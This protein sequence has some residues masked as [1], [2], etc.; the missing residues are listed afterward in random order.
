MSTGTQIVNDAA[1]ACG[2][3]GQGENLSADDSA[4][5]LRRLNRLMDYWSNLRGMVYEIVTDS[6]PA[7]IGTQQYSST[8]LAT[9]GRPVEVTFMYARLN[10]IDYKIDLVSSD[11]WARIPY[12]TVQSVPRVCW[13]DTSF[14][15]D[16]FNLFPVPDNVYTIFVGAQKALPNTIGMATSLAFPPGYEKAIVDVLAVDIAPSFGRQVS[17]DLRLSA[18][19]ATR[20]IECTNF[21][22]IVM[23][24]GLSGPKMTPLEAFY[25]GI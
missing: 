6:F 2:A 21:E 14:P 3:L 23:D 7:V 17:P 13:V 10:S 15:D 4:L 18:D 19:N 11:E 25:R 8:L 24:D 12:K 5:I 1:F 20:A 9:V 16:T 22:P